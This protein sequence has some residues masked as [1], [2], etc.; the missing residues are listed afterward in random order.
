M[1]RATARSRE[2]L[3]STSAQRC[4]AACTAPSGAAREQ[5]NP[6]SPHRLALGVDGLAGALRI[7]AATERIC[8]LLRHSDAKPYSTAAEGTGSTSR[9]Y[10]ERGT[11]PRPCAIKILGKDA[12]NPNAELPGRDESDIRI[13]YRWGT[14]GAERVQSAV[15]E[16][17]SL[18]PVLFLSYDSPILGA[19]RRQTRSIPIVFVGIVLRL[20]F[21]PRRDGM[22]G[23]LDAWHVSGPLRDF[24]CNDFL[25]ETNSSERGVC[26]VRVS[27]A[28]LGGT[29]VSCSEAEFPR[30]RARLEMRARRRTPGYRIARMHPS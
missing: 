5:P 30:E 4:P 11:R 1:S 13:D 25:A 24:R 3:S 20:H 19:L 27:F 18:A 6:H 22:A 15:T 8:L 14:I 26:G 7:I 12:R 29:A 23:A 28:D 9:C 16:L 10:R 17:L 2:P 21:S